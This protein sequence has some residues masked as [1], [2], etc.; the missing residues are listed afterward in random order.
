MQD[1]IDNTQLPKELLEKRCVDLTGEDF[2][3]IMMEVMKINPSPTI[4]QKPTYLRG[5]KA[6]ANHLKCSISTISRWLDCKVIHDDAVIRQNRVL[7]FNVDVIMRQLHE[8]EH[9]RIQLTK[10]TTY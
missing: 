9:L 7:L 6:L 3:I 4:P 5:K 10:L 2:L 1:I 8:N